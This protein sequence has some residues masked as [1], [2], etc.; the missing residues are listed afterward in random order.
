MTDAF[1]A[2]AE[3]AK[4]AAQ[5]QHSTQSSIMDEA[6]DNDGNGGSS[7]F[8]GEKLPGLFNKFVMP[9]TE[10]TGIIVK[11][12]RDRHSRDMDGNLKYWDETTK[13]V[14]THD[15]G[16]KLYDTVIVLQTEYR[17]TPQEIA[18]MNIDPLDV[19]D[20]KGL[21]GVWASGD[22]K[23]AI[24]KAIRQARITKDMGEKALVGMRLTLDRGKK[25]PIPGTNKTKWEGATAKLERVS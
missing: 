11:P 6:E 5:A 24:M 4:V 15:T 14:V 21:R 3:A 17:F 19:E 9:N 25:V 22:L 7:L 23:A 8:G 12:P 20:D 1:T 2:A 10:R 18:D 16:R 13:K